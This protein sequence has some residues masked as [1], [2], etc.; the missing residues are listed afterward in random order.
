[1]AFVSLGLFCDFYFY[2]LAYYC[3]CFGALRYGSSI[4]PTMHYINRLV[5]GDTKICEKCEGEIA[6]KLFEDH[7]LL[8]NVTRVGDQTL[9]C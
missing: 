9:K 8:D 4:K 3:G 1:M 6:K 5:L 7:H 2:F